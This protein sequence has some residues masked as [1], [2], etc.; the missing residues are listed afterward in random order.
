LVF[1]FARIGKL[2]HLFGNGGVS[3][4]FD[5]TEFDIT[6]NVRFSRTLLGPLIGRSIAARMS[7]IES[8]IRSVEAGGNTTPVPPEVEFA[9]MLSRHIDLLKE[10]PAELRHS[11]YQLARIA[12]RKDIGQDDREQGARLAQAL[13]TAIIGVERF[14]SQHDDSVSRNVRQPLNEIPHSTEPPKFGQTLVPYVP[15]EPKSSSPPLIKI[16]DWPIRQLE[17]IVDVSPQRVATRQR[18]AFPW[19]VVSSGL[20][21]VC[22]VLILSSIVVRQPERR[23]AQSF[24]P[25]TQ[26]SAAKSADMA[27]ALTTTLRS[28]SS[29]EAAPARPG[30]EKA[31][32]APKPDFPLPASY[33][34]YAVNNGQLVELHLLEGLVPDKRVAIAGALYMP[35]QT[36][37][38]DRSPTFVVFRRDLAS[39]P[40]DGIEVRV[41]AK[42]SRTLKFDST[43]KSS[44]GYAAEDGLW[45]VRGISYRF[46]SAPVPGN[47]D[48]IVIRPDSPEVVLPPGR[49]ALVLKRQGF[50]FTIAGDVTEPDQCLERTEAAN[51]TF[52]S[53]CKTH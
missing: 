50:D 44:P 10:D 41:I 29:T 45:S 49:Y 1:I 52:Y 18:R 12:L 51:G 26:D 25:P 48:M 22:A 23:L 35:S 47:P 8:V 27:S 38:A 11:V 15:A 33:G 42:I 40:S 16:D 2:V 19:A 30:A 32:A 46:K 13:E 39:I 21:G 28:P 36:V 43:A 5:I 24:S 9:L 20:S 6:E 14:A 53:P 17:P 34:S 3:L 37:L 31:M 7:E 4:W